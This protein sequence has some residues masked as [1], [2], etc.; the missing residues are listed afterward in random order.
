MRKKNT[1]ENMARRV[2]PWCHTC[3]FPSCRHCHRL[4]PL[5]VPEQINIGEFIS[6]FYHILKKN[7]PPSSHT[8]YPIAVDCKTQKFPTPKWFQ[9]SDYTVSLNVCKSVF[10]F[11][12]CVSGAFCNLN[13]VFEV[14]LL[15]STSLSLRSVY[16]FS[17]A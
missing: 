1:E 8:R 17:Y 2:G 15:F 16:M 7:L 14:S 6:R 3:C 12:V 10:A 13:V 4:S 9:S 11:A 5:I